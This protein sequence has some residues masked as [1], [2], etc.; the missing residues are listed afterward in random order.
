MP[1]NKIFFLI[2]AAGKGE[3]LGSDLKK[4]YLPLDNLPV[5]CHTL[6]KFLNFKQPGEII[7]V[8]PADDIMYCK[9]NILEPLEIMTK[10][11]KDIFL[12]PGGKERQDSVQKGLDLIKT[13]SKNYEKDIVLIHDGVR[14]FVNNDLIERCITGA[15]EKGACVPG[16]KAIDTVKEA[17]NDVVLKTLDRNCIYQIQTPQAFLLKIISEAMDHAQDKNF[18]GTDD[19]SLVEFLGLNVS[20]IKGLKYNVKITTTEDLDFAKAYFNSH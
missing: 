3:R 12:V 7:L 13:M 20:I 9:K 18:L 4:Q 17:H 14:P 19:A 10:S 5:L 11:A 15:G 1:D 6:F 16:I 2:V 8:I